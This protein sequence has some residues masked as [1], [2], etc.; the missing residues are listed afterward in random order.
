MVGQGRGRVLE[1]RLGCARGSVWFRASLLR[2]RD[3]ETLRE[4]GRARSSTGEQR[5]PQ[6]VGAR[7]LRAEPL[8]PCA[9]ELLVQPAAPPPARSRPV[10]V[11]AD[12]LLLDRDVAVLRRGRSTPSRQRFRRGCPHGSGRS[13]TLTPVS[14][15]TRTTFALSGSASAGLALEVERVREEHPGEE[16]GQMETVA[17]GVARRSRGAMSDSHPVRAAHDREVLGQLDVELPDDRLAAT[18]LSSSIAS[19]PNRS[20]QRLSISS[21][22]DGQISARALPAGGRGRTIQSGRSPRALP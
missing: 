3:E 8:L 6:P 17:R 13:L 1:H 21:N 19:A 11:R 20:S 9:L 18:P 4:D 22:S 12:G 7:P 14:S 10:G 5:R 15:R 2:G 16:R